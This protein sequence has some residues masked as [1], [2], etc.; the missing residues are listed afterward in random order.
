MNKT[1]LEFDRLDSLI[2]DHH[3]IN[4]PAGFSKRVMKDIELQSLWVKLWE[5]PWVQWAAASIGLAFAM[6][7]LLNYIFSAWLT[8]E[9]AG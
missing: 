3:T 6:G 8:I 5:R 2:N 7:R 9:L 1:D 4:V